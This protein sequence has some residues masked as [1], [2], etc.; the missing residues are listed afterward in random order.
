VNKD[1]A[2]PLIITTENLAWVVGLRG[3]VSRLPGC[4]LEEMLLFE[5]AGAF[6]WVEGSP[7]STRWHAFVAA[8]KSPKVMPPSLSVSMAVNTKA[9]SSFS[10]PAFSKAA[11]NVTWTTFFRLSFWE[12]VG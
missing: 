4:F 3:E 1:T 8:L 9:A 12:A 7:A 5:A 6:A 11:S 10:S 2:P